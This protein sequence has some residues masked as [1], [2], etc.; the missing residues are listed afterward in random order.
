[1]ASDN[2]GYILR[3]AADEIQKLRAFT[4]D[5]LKDIRKMRAKIAVLEINAKRTDP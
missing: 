5:M 4:N 2:G 3:E 1:M